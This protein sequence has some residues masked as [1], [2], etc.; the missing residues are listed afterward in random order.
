MLLYDCCVK[1]K[2]ARK[3][4]RKF[5]RKFPNNQA[6]RRN[7]IQKLVKKLQTSGI[8]IDKKTSHRHTILNEETLRVPT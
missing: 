4:Q 6:P 5:R 2:P 8:L 7:T 3:C 1:H